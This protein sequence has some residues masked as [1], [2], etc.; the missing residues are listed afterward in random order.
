MTML[1]GTIA[2]F[3]R[4][5]RAKL[6]TPWPYVEAMADPLLLLLLFLPLVNAL[7]PM[8][9]LA[10]EDNIQWFAPG[11]LVLMIFT[12]SGFIGAGFQ[13]ERAAGSLERMLVTPASRSAFL[14]GR[15]LRILAIVLVQA[16]VIVAVTSTVGLEVPPVGALLGVALLLLLAATLSITSLMTGL[17]LKDAYA[18]WGIIGVVYTPIIVTSGALLPMEIAPDW[19]HAVSR[20]NPMAHVIDAERA[21]FAGDLT[22]PAIPLALAITGALGVV[23]SAIGVRAMNHLRA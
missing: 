23:A 8:S 1:S 9:G 20:V 15:V 3:D 19:L 21:L 22:N 7:G 10:G 11:M 16:I 12:T 17:L 4:D 5:I 14:A 13:E 18:F 6:R 2:V